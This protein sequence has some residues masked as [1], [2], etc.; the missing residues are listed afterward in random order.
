VHAENS[1][2]HGAREV[3]AQLNGEGIM[4]ARCAVERLTGAPWLTGK[5]RTGWLASVGCCG[6]K[7]PPC[8]SSGCAPAPRGATGEHGAVEA[9]TTAPCWQGS[10]SW[11]PRS[12]PL[13][14]LRTTVGGDG[15]RAADPVGTPV[16]PPG[17][18]TN[19]G[20]G[21]APTCPPSGR[22]SPSRSLQLCPAPSSWR[23]RVPL[24]AGDHPEAYVK[25][26]PVLVAQSAPPQPDHTVHHLREDAP[27]DAF[28]AIRPVGYPEFPAP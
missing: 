5:R 17:T 9:H 3:E 27:M 28:P 15:P 16:H 19:S 11:S 6:R 21:T 18:R 10:P 12:R 14:E 7:D 8:C 24:S 23:I 20:S 25:L 4:V 22:R 13:S 1:G 2:I 26:L